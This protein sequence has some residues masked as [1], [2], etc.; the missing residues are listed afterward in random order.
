MKKKLS[1]GKHITPI[2]YRER[3]TDRQT[4]GTRVVLASKHTHTH[5]HILQ[6]DRQ[7]YRQTKHKVV[8]GC[9]Q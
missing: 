9:K 5:T 3:K 7:T 1:I 2:F 4:E 8:F 6:I